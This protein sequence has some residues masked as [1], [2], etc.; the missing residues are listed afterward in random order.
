MGSRFA[1]FR[2]SFEETDLWVGVDPA[3]YSDRMEDFAA[4]LARRLRLTLDA[5]IARRPEFRTSLAPISS[6]R[7]APAVAAAMIEAARLAGV[8]PMAAVAGAVADFVGEALASE[9][10]CRELAVENGGDLWLR[11]EESLDISVFAGDSPLSEKVGV[12]ISPSYSP[13]G[14]CTSSGTVGPSLSLGRADAAMVACR[15]ISSAHVGFGPAA[16]AGPVALAG[17]AALADAWATAVGNAVETEADIEAAIS[18]ADGKERVVSVL[19]VK[20]GRMGIRGE[21]PLRLF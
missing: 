16:L 1:S 15:A 7:G 5:Y 21:L 2:A 6:D 8:G 3:S 11:F 4:T 13:L 18:L 10:G 19:V 12:S 17:P 9:F 20:G 14:L